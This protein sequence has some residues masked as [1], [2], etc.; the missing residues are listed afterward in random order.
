[1]FAK[2][3]IAAALATALAV[4]WLGTTQAGA[5]S[6]PM[7]VNADALPDLIA[8]NK[9]VIL[10]AQSPLNEKGD[11]PG[12]LKGAFAVDED[13]WT[14]ASRSQNELDELP[15]WDALIGM[16]GI[17]SRQQMVLVYD[18]GDLKFASRI[19]FL[20]Q[21]YGIDR[22]ILVNGGWPA[23]QTLI[24]QGKLQSQPFAS[25]PAIQTYNAVVNNNPI[26]VA[27]RDD[28]RKI[29]LSND[30]S[31]TLIDVRT[32]GE[33]NG[34]TSFPG[35]DR[36]GHIPGAVN[37]PLALLF[38]PK[39]PNMLMNAQGLRTTFLANHID[40]SKPMIFYC[41]DGAR[42]SLGALAA[43]QASFKAVRL[44]YLSYLNWQSF[45]DDPVVG[46]PPKR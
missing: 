41:V 7:I 28:V 18:N 23:I 44:Y 4:L 3:L 33:Y 35:I 36:P 40:P 46:P 2:H 26:P 16:L 19:R 17:G 25:T 31:V 22:A 6:P 5:A 21:H 1:M 15:L 9:P 29:V 43:V 12:F 39:Q 8:A 37:L 24:Q 30:K 10:S 27:T 20:L 14:Y 34:T 32:P 42:S 38:D 45:K 11:E 13:L